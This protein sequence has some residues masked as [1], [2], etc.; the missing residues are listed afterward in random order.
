MLQSVPG[1][2]Y[3]DTNNAPNVLLLHKAPVT[4]KVLILEVFLENQPKLLWG[5]HAGLYWYY[6]DDNYVCILKEQVREDVKL[7]MF[8]EKDSK[9]FISR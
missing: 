9:C 3:L 1:Y 4:S 7:R 8:R 5:K 2:V 6:D